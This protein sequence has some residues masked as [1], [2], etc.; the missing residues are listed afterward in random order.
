MLD[1]TPADWLVKLDN[2]LQA[3]MSAIVRY[4]S[5]YAGMQPL[6]LATAEFRDKFGDLFTDLCDNWCRI[7]VEASVERL[8]V[9]G[10]RW[11]RES[12]AD[13]D[14]WD[15]WQ[16][17]GLDADSTLVHR[18]AVKNGVAYTLVAPGDGDT[19]RITVE[20]PGQ[21]IVATDP[22][23]RRRRLAALKK[24]IDDDGETHQTLYLPDRTLHYASGAPG[25]DPVEVAVNPIGVV[26]V[27]PFPNQPGMLSGGLSDLDVAIPL[28]DVANKTLFDHVVANE[29]LAYPQRT[30]TGIEVPRDPE[31]DQ[32]LDREQ[33]LSSYS[34]LWVSE[35][36]E[37]RFGSLPAA[38]LGGLRELLEVSV[39]HIAALTRTPPHYI[40]GQ[41][42]NVSGDALKAAEAGLTSKVHDKTRWFGEAWE[43]TLRL[44]FAYRGDPKAE[45]DDAEVIWADPET[46]TEGERVDALVKLRAI[47]LPLEVVWEKWGASPQEIERW[48]TLAGLPERP[49]TRPPPDAPPPAIAPPA[50]PG[51]TPDP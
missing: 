15:L 8:R 43:E 25:S 38:D 22:A 23:D 7:I 47:G 32:P 44:A 10:F 31:T 21:V 26:P 14:A 27:V 45:R 51:R 12:A 20:H 11:G 48:K 39:H 6:Q 19:P 36:P 16:R 18:E 49:D 50:P 46:R 13:Q 5:Y 37:V 1:M 17:N 4:E 9:Q 42:V 2:D 29:F 41:M 40:L 35:D 28:Q 34:R 3:R 33:F 24:W 30:A